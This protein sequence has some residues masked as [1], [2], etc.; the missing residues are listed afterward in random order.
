VRGIEQIPWLYDACCAVAERGRLGRWR[1]WLVAG[2]RGLTLDLGCGT[3]RNLPLAP[4]GVRVVG[5]DPNRTV[6]ERARRRAPGVPLVQ[7]AAEALPF[8]DH[9]FQT[10]LS[11]LVF[12]SVEDPERAL[13]EVRR[14]L[15]PQG[16]LRML[17]HVRAT[18]PRLARLQDRLQPF[19]TWLTGGCR[20]NRET[21]RAVE[22]AGFRIEPEGRRARGVWRR[23]QAR[24]A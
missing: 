22:R 23:F 9:V 2:A 8:R 10:V 20:P 12:C 21:E 7:A 24:A 19:W 6:L 3:G 1:R 5:C 15:H 17:E 4:V 11:S 13:A 14:V 18:Q 16:V